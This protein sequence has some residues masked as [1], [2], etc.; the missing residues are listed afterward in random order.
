M[1]QRYRDSV[2]Q[3]RKNY[4]KPFC[5]SKMIILFKNRHALKERERQKDSFY[6]VFSSCLSLARTRR[7]LA[8]YPCPQFTH[9]HSLH[10]GLFI[11][12]FS[13]ASIISSFIL[14]ILWFYV[15]AYNICTFISLFFYHAHYFIFS[16][17]F[18]YLFSFLFPADPE[19]VRCK[20]C[21][22]LRQKHWQQQQ[23]HQ[24]QHKWE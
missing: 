20:K 17:L 7:P 24:H 23:K 14:Y 3:I 6:S 19:C 11:V 22:I 18:A 16:D 4:P 2:M 1:P 21:K 10:T 5:L 12:T 9:I 13:F 8:H 15:H